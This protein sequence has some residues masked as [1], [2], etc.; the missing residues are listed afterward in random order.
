MRLNSTLIILLLFSIPAFADTL[1]VPADYA[2]IQEAIDAS[3][4]GDIVLVSNGLYMENINF[5]GKAITV[6][7]ENGANFTIIDGQ[8]NGTTVLFNHTEDEN[9]VLDG[10]KIQRGSE[11]GI[12]CT[13]ASPTIINCNI[14]LNGTKGGILCTSSNMKMSHCTVTG[15]RNYDDG[16]GLFI[17]M[18]NVTLV[19]CAFYNNKAGSST[20]SKPPSH[21]VY[22]GAIACSHAQATLT[23]CIIYN[24]KMVGGMFVFPHAGGIAN[25]NSS[26]PIKVFNTIV[27]ENY[28][29]MGQLYGAF[30]IQHSNIEYGYVGTG[31]IDEDPLFENAAANNFCLTAGSPC[32]DSGTN[33][34]PNM[35]KFDWEG[36]P[37][38]I[39]GHGDNDHIVDM[40]VDE[41]MMLSADKYTMSQGSG[42]TINFMLDAGPDDAG[43]T[44][45]IPISVSGT[46]PGTPLPGGIVTLPLNWDA[47][48]DMLLNF[49]NTP[50]LVDFHGQLDAE[51]KANAQLNIGPLPPGTVGMSAYFAFTCN[52]PFDLASHSVE[53]VVIP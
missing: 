15:N 34:A 13:G 41:F 26:I 1:L 52:N 51:G 12:K 4:N 7:G 10:F 29:S 21:H 2:T 53:V 32:I 40:G 11:G 38:I 6:K 9:S 20:M 47:M 16:G 22:G 28:D 19:N 30:D 5:M 35:P 48:T 24:N 3:Q 45:L 23:N 36:D 14:S 39:D 8:N 25:L 50:L 31:N 42:E 27:R 37:R 44:Y 18:G 46:D 49:V 43:R 33:T 17:N